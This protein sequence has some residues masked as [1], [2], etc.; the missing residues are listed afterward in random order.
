MRPAISRFARSRRML[1]ALLVGLSVACGGGGGGGGG[2]QATVVSTAP[3]ASPVASP[4]RP[5]LASPVTGSS[6]V[7]PA[8]SASPT[9]ATNAGG[10][11]GNEQT[12]EIQSGDTLLSIAEQFYGDN[13]QWRKIYDANRDVIGS[14]PDALEVGTTLKIPPKDS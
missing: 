14:N 8:V 13:S 3:S 6:P 4:Q 12:Y 7:V 2:S 11:G 1:A 5:A 10:G 9:T